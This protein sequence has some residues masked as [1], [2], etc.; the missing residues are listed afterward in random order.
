MTMVDT[1]AAAT[2][3]LLERLSSRLGGPVWNRRSFLVRT[4]L[5]GSAVA[6]APKEFAL[7]P[8]TAYQ[9]VCG[10]SAN[11]H[12]GY[13]GF[14]CTINGG[15]NFCPTGTFIAGWWKADRASFCGGKARYYIDCNGLPNTEWHCH[16]PSTST[17]DKRHVSCVQFRYG[18]CHTEIAIDVKKSPVVC[19][20]VTCTPPWQFDPACTT[21]SFT[22]QE[23]VTHSAPCLPGPNASEITK[24]WS[25]LGGRGGEFGA[26]VGSVQ[27]T[28]TAS[29]TWQR[30][31]HGAVFDIKGLGLFA[32]RPKMWNPFGATIALG[33]WGYPSDDEHVSQDNIGWRQVFQSPRGAKFAPQAVAT[34]H[35]TFGSF[36]VLAPAI[37]PWS[38]A[39]AESGLGYPIATTAQ[40]VGGYGTYTPLARLSKT[41]Q[42]LLSAV[43]TSNCLGGFVIRDAIFTAWN[44]AGG[45][46]GYG[47]PLGNQVQT[48][49]GVGATQRFALIAGS[50]VNFAN[51]TTLVTS[52]AGTYAI[53]GPLAIAWSSDQNLG[54]AIG[55]PTATPVLGTA[56]ST[57]YGELICTKGRLYASALC[58]SSSLSGQLL[59]AYLL[60]GGPLGSL[61]LPL[62]TTVSDSPGVSHVSFEHGTLTATPSGV[63]QS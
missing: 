32:V 38:V 27:A 33:S 6:I 2:K 20:L 55:L 29:G 39:G 19:R 7:E 24:K 15:G 49:G 16:C 37:G 18:N 48:L 44:A 8:R 17:C 58:S 22:D 9:S 14:C 63:T 61:G 40:T 36:A 23:T 53:N 57:P 26:P 43:V 54:G 1:I 46:A 31:A 47:Y 30:Y 42:R 51:S 35:P 4:A 60:A 3:P 12:D 56:G 45:V 10:L 11:C 5:F 52:T 34:V 25:D 50:T 59:A 62:T 41:S 21:A 13:T 28:P